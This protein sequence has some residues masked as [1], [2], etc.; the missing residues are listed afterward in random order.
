V[1]GAVPSMARSLRVGGWTQPVGRRRLRRPA[2]AKRLPRVVALG[3]A[4]ILLAGCAGGG[5]STNGNV[6]PP[7]N[8]NVPSPATGQG[9]GQSTLRTLGTLP[10][11]PVATTTTSTSQPPPT[12]EPGQE[13]PTT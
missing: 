1:P 6:P 2:S 4:V 3:L 11:P 13:P 8:P 5:A 7:G 10:G 9:S 12:T